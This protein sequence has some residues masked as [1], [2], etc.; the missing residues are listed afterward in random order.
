VP[1][2]F[3]LLLSPKRMTDESC[4]WL[5]GAH[6]VILKRSR[7]HSGY[8]GVCRDIFYRTGSSIRLPQ[9]GATAKSEWEEDDTRSVGA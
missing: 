4:N 6:L 1:E 9:L 8:I 5:W 3:I 7:I 2:R